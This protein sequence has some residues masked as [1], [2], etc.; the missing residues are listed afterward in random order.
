MGQQKQAHKVALIFIA[1][2]FHRNKYGLTER[3]GTVTQTA[4]IALGLHPPVSL[5]HLARG[6]QAPS[7]PGQTYVGWS[8]HLNQS[9]AHTI[10]SKYALQEIG[11]AHV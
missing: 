7:P 10:N 8:K 6:L 4:A 2:V 5:T 1:L 3:F 11:R 9:K